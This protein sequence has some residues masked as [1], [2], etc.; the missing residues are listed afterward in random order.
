MALW[1]AAQLGLVRWLC[2]RSRM[3]ARPTALGSSDSGP[4]SAG[5]SGGGWHRRRARTHLPRLTGDVRFELD[6]VISVTACERRPN[7]WL[8]AR[9]SITFFIAVPP[10]S[11]SW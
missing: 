11:G 5:G 3:V 9:S 8:A 7:R 4:A 1:Q 2:M 6:V 10:G